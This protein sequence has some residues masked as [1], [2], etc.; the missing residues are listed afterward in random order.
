[1][2]AFLAR[3]R[4]EFAIHQPHCSG[5]RG[6]GASECERL[7]RGHRFAPRITGRVGVDDATISY[8]DFPVSLS[9]MKGDFVFDRSRLLFDQVTAQAGGGQLTLTGSVSYGEGP[10]RYEVNAA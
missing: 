10:L 5:S 6:P 9:H 4:R 2:A 7:R 8:S 3:R 1:P